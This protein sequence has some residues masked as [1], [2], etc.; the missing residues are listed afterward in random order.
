MLVA[1]DA[2]GAAGH[3]TRRQQSSSRDSRNFLAVSQP[4]RHERRPRLSGIFARRR[5][6]WRR[7]GSRWTLGRPSAPFRP[8][9]SRGRSPASPLHI[10]LSLSG[11][12]AGARPALLY[13]QVTLSLSGFIATLTGARPALLCD[14]AVALRH[15]GYFACS[16]LRPG[17]R[18]VLPGTW[19]DAV[20]VVRSAVSR[21]SGQVTLSLSGFIATSAGTRPALFCGRVTWALSGIIAT[22]IG[23]RPALRSD[24]APAL[25]LALGLLCSTARSRCRSLVYRHVCLLL[26]CSAPQSLLCSQVSGT[27]ATFIGAR[28]ALAA[29]LRHHRYDRWRSACAALLRSGHAGALRHHRYVRWLLAGSGLRSDRAVALRLHCYAH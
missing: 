28:P 19:M 2:P 4:L 11:I 7:R 26:A 20:S 22:L 3:A 5:R 16:A 1:R 27:I 21:G 24:R 17:Q 18:S 13:G 23:A 29:A 6:R 12:V 15:R 8:F 14:R 10:A 9:R 25:S